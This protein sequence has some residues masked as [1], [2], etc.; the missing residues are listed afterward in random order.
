MSLFISFIN[1]HAEHTR[2]YITRV[3][4][5]CIACAVYQYITM[6]RYGLF[7][8]IYI[9]TINPASLR[10]SEIMMSV[11]DSKTNCILFVSVAQVMCV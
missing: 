1:N 4:N 7:L 9:Y 10:C 11:T 2:W 8:D 5:R 6:T 3:Y